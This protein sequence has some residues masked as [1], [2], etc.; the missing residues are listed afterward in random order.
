VVAGSLAAALLVAIAC[1][2][3]PPA[4][5]IHFVQSSEGLPRTGEWR[6]RFA[7]ADLDGDGKAEII[8]PPSRKEENPHPHI[9]SRTAQ[10]RWEEWP[11]TFPEAP[12]NYGDVV[13][14]DFDHDGRPD[15]AFACHSHGIIV[16]LN[17]GD[18]KWEIASAGL[19][20]PGEFP[21]RALAAGD[22]DGD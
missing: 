8:A 21:T 16:V 5:E 22:I 2:R 15:L 10:G 18:R 12:Y 9:W 17:R 4:P 7:V 6:Q 3:T 11:N 20:A 1:H 14:A 13:V 19:P